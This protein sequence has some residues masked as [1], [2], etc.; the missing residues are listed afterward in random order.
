MLMTGLRFVAW[1]P[2]G[3]RLCGRRRRGVARLC[4]AAAMSTAMSMS[5]SAAEVQVSATQQ[6]GFGSFTAGSGTVSVTPSGARTTTGNVVALSADPG[7]A[8][9]FL[10]S[11]DPSM[12]YAITLPV[13]GTVTLSNGATDMPVNGFVSDPAS[14]G[15][16]PGSGSQVLSVG[17]TLHVATDQPTGSYSGSFSVT[18]NYN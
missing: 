10:V 18:V 11:G 4:A 5:V 9:Q 1:N 14:S 17:A 13:D 12:T 3:A 7:Q 15:V 16:L 6:L 2:G 8:A